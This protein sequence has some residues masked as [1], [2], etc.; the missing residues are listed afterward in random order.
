MK[1]ARGPEYM[2]GDVPVWVAPYSVV[3]VERL[4]PEG[5]G[6]TPQRTISRRVRTRRTVQHGHRTLLHGSGPPALE[7]SRLDACNR[8]TDSLGHGQH[9]CNSR[10][11]TLEATPAASCR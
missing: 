7:R 1:H 10:C 3:C 4:R 6:S 5:G 2:H 8:A 11:H 9:M